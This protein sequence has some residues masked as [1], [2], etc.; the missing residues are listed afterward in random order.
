MTPS[1]GGGWTGIG[2][3]GVTEESDGNGG[4]RLGWGAWKA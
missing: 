1:L 3:G 4:D 2:N